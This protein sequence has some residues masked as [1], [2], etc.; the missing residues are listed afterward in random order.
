MAAL[1]SAARQGALYRRA[2]NLT[3]ATSR[4]KRDV[5]GE[6]NVIFLGRAEMLRM[7]R[8]YLGHDFD[9]DVITFEHDLPP[10]FNGNDLPLGDIFISA[11]MTRRQ[12]KELGHSIATEAA[13]LAVHGALHL[14]GYDDHRPG[15]KARMFKVQDRVVA[16]LSV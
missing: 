5:S 2:V 7:N 6:I 10:G 9:T 14:L 4:K 12:A 8:H 16:S 15:P 1:P 3:I 11:W 13:T